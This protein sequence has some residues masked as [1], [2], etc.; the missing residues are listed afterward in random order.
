MHMTRSHVTS[1]RRR[2]RRGFTLPELMVA[3]VMLA[4][5]GAALMSMLVKQQRFYR[6]TGDVMDLRAQL[7]QASQ[8]I[9]ADLRGISSVGSDII[10]MTDSSIDFRQ[11][12]GS[13]V[14]CK[15]VAKGGTNLVLAPQTLSSGAVLTTWL[16]APA[17]GDSIM[18]FD[19]GATTANS[20]DSWQTFAVAGDTAKSNA[21][22]TGTG[23][24]T[25]AGETHTSYTVVTSGNLDT[26]ITVGSPVRF[27]HYAHYSLYKA[28]D[29]KWYLGFCQPACSSTNKITAVA[30]PFRAYTAAGGTD[31]SGIRLTYYDSTGAV[32]ATKKNVARI[33][34]VIRG[35]TQNPVNISGFKSA[36]KYDSLSTVV[37]VRN[38][39]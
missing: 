21:C 36:T 18:V 25:A 2:G 38:R 32:T 37:A 31:T 10:A 19:E 4:I 28:S 14:V 6:G 3:T 17:P 33:G 29:N 30:G 5:I 24:F 11:T 13:S 12:F 9:T 20:D 16:A 27:Y 39:S 26:N 15:V 23:Y 22:P 34:I 7:R 35:A 8:A 1:A